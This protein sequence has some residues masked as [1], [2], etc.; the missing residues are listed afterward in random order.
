MVK[1]FLLRFCSNYYTMTELNIVGSGLVFMKFDNHLLEGWA[2]EMKLLCLGLIFAGAII[3]AYS[4]IRYYLTL[5]Y[6]KNQN[7]EQKVF[8]NWIY[9]ASFSMM[10]FFFIG[11]VGV[12][13]TLLS[14]EFEAYYLMI[15]MIFFFGA[16]FVFCMVKVQRIMAETITDKTIETIQSMVSAMEAKDIYTRGHSEHVRNLVLL[17]Y[18]YLPA[19]LKSK[20]NIEKLKDAAILHDVG[21]IGIPDNILNKPDRLTDEEYEIIKQHPKN[22][23]SILEHTCYRD[24]SDWILYHHERVDGKGYYNMPGHAIPFESK[25]IAL[26][27]TFSA[28]YTDRIYRKRFSLDKV[29][30]ILKESAGTQLDENLVDLFCSISPDEINGASVI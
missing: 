23:K 13:V 10:V 17:I 21:K 15:S 26:A 1:E 9:G 5:G 8:N 28:L 14:S 20:L 6:M 11:Y 19:Q 24:I 30:S 3:M 2:G 18:N 4:I 29:L 12:G 22:A 16:L 25:I 27:D 7:Y